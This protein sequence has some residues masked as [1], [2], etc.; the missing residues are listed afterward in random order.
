MRQRTVVLPAGTLLH[1]GTGSDFDPD[2][3][4]AP[5]WF[6]RSIEVARHF[7]RRSDGGTS[8]ILVFS[9]DVDVELPLISGSAAF[10]AFCERHHI[11]PYSAEDMADGVSRAGLAGW[12]IPDNYPDGD[13]ILLVDVY[14]L[15]F[16]YEVS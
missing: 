5:C 9:T 12:L 2:E 1:H 8:R 15:T 6:S 13:D 3:I 14:S 4:M 10:D 7:C 16:Q 11:R